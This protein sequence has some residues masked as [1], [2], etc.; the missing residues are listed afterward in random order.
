MNTARLDTGAGGT[1][2]SSIVFG[3]AKDPG[4]TA[5]NDAEVWDGSSWTEVANLNTSRTFLGG[6]ASVS[7]QALAYGGSSPGYHAVTE[8]WNG[9]SWTEVSDL[10]TAKG[11][12]AS[13]GTYT[14]AVLVGSTIPP[15]AGTTNV[16]EYNGTSWS[17][18]NDVSTAVR[19]NAGAGGTTSGISFGGEP[20]VTAT[21]EF[22][23]PPPTA[24]VLTEGQI[25][26]SGG[27]TLK[28]FGRFGGIPSGT[29]ASGALMNTAR[30]DLA[31]AGISNS[32]A[33]MF[34]GYAPA[35]PNA[36]VGATETYDGSS[37]TEVA[38][39]NTAR[40]QLNSAKNGT[41][42]ATLVIAGNLDN[43]TNVANVEEWN[44]SSWTET[45]DLNTARRAGGGSGTS[46]AALYFGGR[47]PD[48][49]NTE[50]WDGSSWTEV[51]DLNDARYYLG[52]WGTQ[53]SSIAAGGNPN[54]ANT[55]TWDGS[56]WTEVNNL[57][58]GR[59]ELG[60]A[61]PSTS[62]GLVFGGSPYTNTKTEFWNGTSW[63]ELNDMGSGKA[64]AGSNGSSVSALYAA[65]EAPP[66][67][68]TTQEWTAANALSTITVS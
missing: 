8:Q 59:Q 5:T 1:Q 32:S 4:N 26:L 62:D 9:S 51:A 56:S 45:G 64:A 35:A 34:G 66:K 27:T 68:N 23:F 53:T 63:T 44:G 20:Q 42:T 25:F 31:G 22:S 2:T 16:E 41:Q 19:Q 46:T 28:G 13:Y 30:A 60:S 3:G 50:S 24:A 29:W 43:G 49:A 36:N 61:G 21:E 58:T 54:T 55:E 47:L 11:N 18:V 33:V 7:T 14:A 37:F 10:S 40:S 6:A 52:S 67:T 65:G 12:G 39:M 48:Y 17:E 38:D 57:N 15:G